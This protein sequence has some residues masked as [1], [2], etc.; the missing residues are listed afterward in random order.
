MTIP[1]DGLEPCVGPSTLRRLAASWPGRA[2]IRTDM[3][4]ITRADNSMPG[5]P[6]YPEHLIPFAAHPLF[7]EAPLEQRRMVNTLA[8][9]GFNAR[10]IAV[11][12][13]IVNP[14]FDKIGSNFFPGTEGDD[15]KESVKQAQIDEV[16][17]TY[18][19]MLAL[20]KAQAVAKIAN[21]PDY[22][23]PLPSRRLHVA[24]SEVSETWERDLLL[25]LWAVVA[26]ISVSAYLELVARDDTIQPMHALV[27]RLH[28]R[29][30]SAHGSIMYDIT[31]KIYHG[32]T[33]SQQEFFV[34]SF[35]AAITAFGAEDYEMWPD[36]LQT[37]RMPGAIEIVHDIQASPGHD[38]LVN[39]FSGIQRL[40]RELEIH[41]AVEFDF[42]ALQHDHPAA[43]QKT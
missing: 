30:E 8:W 7:L 15:V 16:W 40:L 29:D 38:F 31:K 5:S 14:A 28:N 37:A 6:D 3:E 1:G 34:R 42:S 41:D 10:V 11:E 12:D 33:S 43:T 21:H 19:H 26:E 18:M 36:I 27:A 32:M 17:H 2:T 35:P 25:L 23:H 20:K 24:Q 39:D 9:L 4:R 13:F 22:I